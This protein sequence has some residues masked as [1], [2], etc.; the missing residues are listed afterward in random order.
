LA[1]NVV[2]GYSETV[3]IN[4]DVTVLSAT[5][6]AAVINLHYSNDTGNHQEEGE[7]KVNTN[8][9][10]MN[11][12]E[13]VLTTSVEET[14]QLMEETAQKIVISSEIDEKLNG[15]DINDILNVS[16]NTSGS[17][18]AGVGST[19]YNYHCSMC[20]IPYSRQSVHI[21]LANIGKCCLCK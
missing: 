6:T 21:G 1:C 20:H 19:S 13:F 18:G 9:K 15:D 5:G 4:D 14:I 12:K 3:S 10:L 17:G 2:L 8:S 16:T 11:P 7:L